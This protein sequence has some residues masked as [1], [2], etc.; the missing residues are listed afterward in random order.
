MPDF[1]QVVVA[2]SAEARAGALTTARAILTEDNTDAL[3]AAIVPRVKKALPK[4]LQWLPI[5]TILDKILP[6]TVLSVVEEVLS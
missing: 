3:I 6:G 1:T 5:G 4:Y 2:V